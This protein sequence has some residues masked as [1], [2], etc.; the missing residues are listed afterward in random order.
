MYGYNEA[1]AIRWQEIPHQKAGE[2]NEVVKKKHQEEFKNE[3]FAKMSK[4]S[5]KCIKSTTRE[6]RQN[7]G[8]WKGVRC[9]VVQ[10][11]AFSDEM[12]TAL[13]QGKYLVIYLVINYL[14]RFPFLTNRLVWRS[15]V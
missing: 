5:G 2:E 14:V 11:C 12:L 8:S 9:S 4:H 1:I 6:M 10:C 13:K 7:D 15:T 3:W